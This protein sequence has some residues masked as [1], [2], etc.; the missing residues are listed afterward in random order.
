MNTRWRIGLALAL[1]PLLVGACHE[2]PYSS[3]F[4]RQG[5]GGFSHTDKL[6]AFIGKDFF[7]CCN[8][9]F[10]DDGT[11]T[12]AN[13]LFIGIANN[14]LP[15]GTPVPVTGRGPHGLE[16]QPQVGGR[17]FYIAFQYGTERMGPADYFHLILRDTDSRAGLQSTNPRMQKAIADGRLVRGMS[18]TQALLARGYPPFHQTSGVESDEWIYFDAM[19]IIKRVRFVAGTIDSI[20]TG[21]AP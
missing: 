1:V 18:K 2:R 9:R 11:T 5:Q 10:R 15:A 20:E 13:Y 17:R 3:P 12:D 4:G 21:Q 14:F 6:N 8:L 7:T 19:S 16:I